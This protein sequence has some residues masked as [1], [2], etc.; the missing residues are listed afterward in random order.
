VSMTI[1]VVEGGSPHSSGNALFSGGPEVYQ[2]AVAI[3]PSERLSTL[4]LLRRRLRGSV[5]GGMKSQGTRTKSSSMR[6]AKWRRMAHVPVLL[7]GVSSYVCMS[8][9]R[10]DVDMSEL[11]W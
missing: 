5:G 4:N 7:S 2:Q 6:C 8:I 3:E 1:G 10:V 11:T 9:R